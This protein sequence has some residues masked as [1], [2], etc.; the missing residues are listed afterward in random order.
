[1]YN[2]LQCFSQNTLR[3]EFE[4]IGFLVEELYSDVAGKAFSSESPEMAIVA[5]KA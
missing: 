2:W 1:V 3:H 4:E 5:K